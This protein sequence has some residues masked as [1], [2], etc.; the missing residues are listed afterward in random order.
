MR[1]QLPP[2][3]IDKSLEGYSGAFYAQEYEKKNISGARRSLF[4][5]VIGVFLVCGC[6]GV[7]ADL[8]EGA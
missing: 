6:I 7:R 4:A 3:S 2:S 5:N 1:I 8:K